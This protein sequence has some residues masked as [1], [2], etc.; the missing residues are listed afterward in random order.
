MEFMNE[1]GPRLRELLNEHTTAP[2]IDRDRMWAGVRARQSI[3]ARRRGV[4]RWSMV[5]L[6][7]SVTAI[8]VV[9]GLRQSP[10]AEILPGPFA[11]AADSNLTIPADSLP[12]AEPMVAQTTQDPT[13]LPLLGNRTQLRMD[14]D[15]LMEQRRDLTSELNIT[16]LSKAQRDLIVRDLA[17]I[18]QQ[19]A[20]SKRAL[21]AIDQELA[22]RTPVAGEAVAAPVEHITTHVDVPPIPVPFFVGG[23]VIPW[24]AGTGA[25]MVLLVMAT[26]MWV[27]RSVRATLRELATLR[28]QSG[29]QLTALSEGVEAIALEVERIGEGQR[30]LSK[31]VGAPNQAEKS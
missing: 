29:T 23:D 6:G 27:R 19:L 8:A 12:G 26:L 15:H 13:L 25:A 31:M 22:G 21:N 11:V 7:T 18:E 10:V 17:E 30:Y 1:P 16:S 24:V 3:R 4:L 20:S 2:T 9:F 5:G 14:I 28:T